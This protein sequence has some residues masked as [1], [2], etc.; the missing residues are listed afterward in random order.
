MSED[1]DQ[2]AADT[3]PEGPCA[4]LIG[5]SIRYRQASSLRGRGTS[6]DFLRE[7]LFI[8][9]FKTRP[10]LTAVTE[11]VILKYIQ[12]DDLYGVDRRPQPWLV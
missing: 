9:Y 12:E 11:T 5:T 4:G 1:E 2:A 7:Q 8:L 3:K 6:E 10:F